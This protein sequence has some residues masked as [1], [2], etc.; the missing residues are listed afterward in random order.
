MG[1]RSSSLEASSPGS[2]R[3]VSAHLRQSSSWTKGDWAAETFHSSAAELFR[4]AI[5]RCSRAWLA[6]TTLTNKIQNNKKNIPQSPTENVQKHISFFMSS[7]D[8]FFSVFAVFLRKTCTYPYRIPHINFPLIY[9]Y[10]YKAPPCLLRNQFHFFPQSNEVPAR[11]RG[12]YHTPT[13]R[14][15]ERGLRLPNCVAGAFFTFSFFQEGG[16]YSGFCP[17]FA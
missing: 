9:S 12:I 13:I 11:P 17:I 10:Q 6:C 5:S 16:V 4:C 14:K 8:Y 1:R 15:F 2:R 3:G 7:S